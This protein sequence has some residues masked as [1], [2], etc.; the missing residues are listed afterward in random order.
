MLL[1]KC[2]MAPGAGGTPPP[3]PAPVPFGGGPAQLTAAQLECVTAAVGPVAVSELQT[4]IRLPTTEEVTKLDACG[5]ALG[6][7]GSQ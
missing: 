6:P 2:G 5:V 1:L 3:T 4:G 7:G